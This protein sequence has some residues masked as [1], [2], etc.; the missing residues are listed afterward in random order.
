MLGARS[1]QFKG[2]INCFCCFDAS[3]KL[4]ESMDIRSLSV[5]T[6]CFPLY[7]SAVGLKSN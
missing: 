2:K 6:G 7:N 1:W 5:L 4:Y 3:L